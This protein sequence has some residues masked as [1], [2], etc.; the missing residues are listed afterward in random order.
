VKTQIVDPARTTEEPVDVVVSFAGRS[1]PVAG[2]VSGGSGGVA[3]PF[4]GWLE[5]MDA[6][7]S[8][9]SGAEPGF[10]VEEGPVS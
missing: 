8:T 1:G 4:H 2:S 6:L 9:R 5:L 3:S 7:E 10:G